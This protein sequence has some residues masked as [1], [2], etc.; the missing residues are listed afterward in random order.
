MFPILIL[1]RAATSASVGVWG[2]A[3]LAVWEGRFGP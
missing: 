3:G 1:V 2:L